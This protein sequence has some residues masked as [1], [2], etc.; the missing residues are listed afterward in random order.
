MCVYEHVNRAE[1]VGVQGGGGGLRSVCVALRR[2]RSR[3]LVRAR[4][5]GVAELI[6]AA[7]R[8]AHLGEV[9]RGAY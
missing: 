5:A 8:S 6:K 1:G 2:H 9:N 4:G 7:H 3:A